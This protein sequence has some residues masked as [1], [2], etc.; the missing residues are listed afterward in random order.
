MKTEETQKAMQVL[1]C[2]INSGSHTVKYE[3]VNPAHE[4]ALE[5]L[6]KKVPAQEIVRL[7]NEKI[8]AHHLQHELRVAVRG[9]TDIKDAEKRKAKLAELAE[10][11]GRI[12]KGEVFDLYAFLP[13]R[14]KDTDPDKAFA[15]RLASAK[16]PEE[17][18]ALLLEQLA[19]L[20]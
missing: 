16:T 15:K 14:K 2:Q 10:T 1:E 17:R 18:K 7:V 6:Q 5:E 20:E 4:K 19:R 8:L 11:K 12:E 13:S 3:A 9:E